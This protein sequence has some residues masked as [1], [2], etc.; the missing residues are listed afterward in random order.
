VASKAVERAVLDVCVRT[1]PGFPQ[2]QA[3]DHERPDFLVKAGNRTIGIEMQEFIQRA[4]PKG[5]DAREAESV[6][7][8]IMRT[9]QLAFESCHPSAH[10]YVYGHWRR[11][12]LDP[13][14]TRELADHVADLVAT[15]IPA[16]EP[17]QL[18][19]RRHASYLE[20]EGFGLE[21]R[22]HHVD[23]LRYSRATYGL[24]ASPEWGMFSRDL[25][26]L[27][28]QIGAKAAKLALYR[29]SCDE[30]W[31]VMYGLAYPSGGFDMDGL[32]GRRVESLFDHIV[33][34]DVVSGNYVLLAG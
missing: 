16:H 23:V 27:E 6:R 2:A 30:I 11:D 5:A 12:P 34:I 22:L 18:M 25:A 13:R 29:Q 14:L 15:L 20:L 19:T 10:L 26:D 8:K 4:G 17:G 28:N 7:D 9:A 24:W 33:F 21:D 31:L 3:E 1:V 32:L